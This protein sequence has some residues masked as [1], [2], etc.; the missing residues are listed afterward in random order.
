MHLDFYF[1]YFNAAIECQGQQH[2]IDFDYWSSLE[3]NIERDKLKKKL[4]EENGI[5]IYYYSEL[6]IKYPYFVYENFDEMMKDVVNNSQ[7]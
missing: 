2:F 6:G 5:K 1:P 3:D 4:C 7:Q